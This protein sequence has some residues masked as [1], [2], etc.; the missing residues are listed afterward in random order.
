MTTNVK[1]QTSTYPSNFKEQSPCSDT[2]S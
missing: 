1:H 2:D